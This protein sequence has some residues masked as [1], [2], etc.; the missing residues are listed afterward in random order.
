MKVGRRNYY[1]LSFLDVYS[2]CVVPWGLLRWMDGVSVGVE[3]AAA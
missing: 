2:R 1:L 3:A